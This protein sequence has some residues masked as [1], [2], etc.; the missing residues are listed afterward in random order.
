MILDSIKD[1][2]KLVKTLELIPVCI[3]ISPEIERKI[4]INGEL[5]K[6]TF[7]EEHFG[8]HIILDS[9]IEGISIGV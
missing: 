3:I 4:F 8:L 1:K 7:L 5:P 6:N 9:K 2:I